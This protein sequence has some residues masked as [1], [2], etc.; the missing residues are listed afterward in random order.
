[1]DKA[2]RLRKR[3]ATLIQVTA[4]LFLQAYSILP[5]FGDFVAPPRHGAICS[6]DHQICGCPLE[7][8]ANRTCGCFKSGDLA[9]SLMEQNKS[10]TRPISAADITRMARF[11]SPPC[12]DHPDIN[13]ASI[14]KIIFLRS[15]ATP[16]GPDF[17]SALNPAVSGD[18]L[19]TRSNEPPD[20]PPK[21]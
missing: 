20:P 16:E 15:A 12:G 1:M 21:F 19:R 6:G 9:K 17:L 7:K 8:I 2:A 3:V 18:P 10:Q 13:I 4:L 11:V 14:E 5:V